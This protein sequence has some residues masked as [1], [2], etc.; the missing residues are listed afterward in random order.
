M[1]AKKKGCLIIVCSISSSSSSITNAHVQV[2]IELFVISEHFEVHFVEVVEILDHGSVQLA[3]EV[4]LPLGDGAK[5]VLS[6]PVGVNHVR[7]QFLRK[8]IKLK[9]KCRTSNLDHSCASSAQNL[10]AFQK[11]KRNKIDIIL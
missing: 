7:N 6:L 1:K 11:V 8:D 2:F 10:G 4:L 5:R 9:M 3:E